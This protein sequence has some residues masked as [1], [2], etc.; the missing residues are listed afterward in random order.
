MFNRELREAVDAC[1]PGHDD[2]QL[3]EMASLRE[4]L[5]RDEGIRRLFERTR[6][7]DT[8]IAR[9]MRDVAVPEG[10]EQR[11]LTAVQPAVQV[12][13]DPRSAVASQVASAATGAPAEESATVTTA[14]SADGPRR[15]VRTVRWRRW[16]TLAAAV[17]G[18]AAVVVIA[19]LVGLPKAPA[20]LHA[21]AIVDEV[22]AWT[23]RTEQVLWNEDLG[24]APAKANIQGM[25]AKQPLRWAPIRT[26]YDPA[27]V[28]YDLAAPGQEP[29]FLFCLRVR[30]RLPGV[31]TMPP[32]TPDATS[33][34][35]AIGVWQQGSTVYALSVQGGERRYRAFIDSESLAAIITSPGAPSVPDVPASPRGPALRRSLSLG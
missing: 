21:Q 24:S 26:G 31:S 23:E 19:L 32:W 33:G 12:G 15:A 27:A 13:G 20:P 34:G 7:I 22:R 25:L 9:A 17:G 16:P 10:L 14:L 3:P 1:R 35:L 28:V 18:V 11:L 29:A 5:V 8:E 30:G 6:R 4:V 2:L